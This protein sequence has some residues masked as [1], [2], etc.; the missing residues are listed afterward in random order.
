M[1]TTAIVLLLITEGT[2]GQR[3]EMA[4]VCEPAYP[5]LPAGTRSR[6]MWIGE[7]LLD[8]DGNVS[9]VWTIRQP[10]LTP[11]FPAFN[12]AIVDAVR[13]WQSEPFIV[14]LGE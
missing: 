11:S 13:Q 9:H 7:M 14:R 2:T 3:P 4:T 10:R 5:D 8:T 1:L 6:G 12:R